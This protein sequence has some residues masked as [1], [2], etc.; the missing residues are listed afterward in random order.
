MPAPSRAALISRAALLGGALTLAG[1]SDFDI[2]LRNNGAN[3]SAAAQQATADLPSA[4]DRG[5]ISYPTYQVAVARRGDTVADVATRVGVSPDALA[6]HNAMEPGTPL[7]DGEILA[8]HTRVSEPSPATGSVT[9]GP[10]QSPDEIDITSIAGGAIERA[11]TGQPAV[12]TTA[13]GTKVAVAP[14]PIRHQVKRGET[15]YS[16]SRTYGV[17]VSALAEWNGL[18][19]QLELREGQY[20]LIPV[21][22]QTAPAPADSTSLPGAASVLA[23]PPSAAAPLPEDEAPRAT[24]VATPQSPDLAQDATASSELAYPVNG[25]IMRG[26]EKKVNEGI[27]ISA[28]AGSPVK[29]AKSGTVAAIT[30]DTDQVPILVIRHNDSLLTVYANIDDI[31]VSKGD[32]V[33]RGQTIAKV[34]TGDPAFL[35]FEVREGFESVDPMSYL[36]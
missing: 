26:F 2:D 22:N 18:G 24:P 5:V 3:T 13:E 31:T 4:D 35:H 8:L 14:E 36:E 6:A 30:R 28:S 23:A 12:A 19:P 17:S 25:P 16:I 29:A 15:A 33:T 21:T 32:S 10:I 27:D 20:L 11:S 1:C 7:R 34:R 9:T